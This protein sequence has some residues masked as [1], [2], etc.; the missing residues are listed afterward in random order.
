MKI[1]FSVINILITWSLFGQVYVSFN[2]T[3]T[4][5]YC[6]GAPKEIDPDQNIPKPTQRTLFVYAFN[7]KDSAVAVTV[8][9]GD[10]VQLKAGKYIV[11]FG[12]KLSLEQIDIL[13]N[14]QSNSK[15]ALVKSNYYNKHVIV[16]SKK[17][18]QLFTLNYHV[19]CPWELNPDI[20][21][22]GSQQH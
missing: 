18:Q 9:S 7:Q 12:E 22:P 2:T 21:P 3:T 11:T 15:I 16:V 8:Q 10:T 4:S 5:S 14:S 20:P 19:Y 1:L 17:K 6:Q 13:A